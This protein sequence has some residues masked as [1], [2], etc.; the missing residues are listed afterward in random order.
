MC[1]LKINLRNV[2]LIQTGAEVEMGLQNKGDVPQ[3][4]M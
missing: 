4:T 2:R 1:V 3:E